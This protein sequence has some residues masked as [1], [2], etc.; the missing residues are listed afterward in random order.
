MKRK[1]L[2]ASII[3]C[4]VLVFTCVGTG[5]ATFFFAAQP[6]KAENI[7]TK[8]D[9]IE[10]NYSVSDGS[11][12]AENYYDVYFFAQS[13]AADTASYSN[14]Q[15]NY[16]PVSADTES[17][18][19]ASLTFFNQWSSTNRTVHA[20]EY[21]YW[22]ESTIVSNADIEIQE[23]RSSYNGAYDYIT[24]YKDKGNRPY[25]GYKHLR[26]YQSITTEQFEA[27]GNPA[28]TG[29]DYGNWP[30]ENST[31]EGHNQLDFSGWTANRAVASQ[32]AI[33]SKPKTF[34]DSYIGIPYT[35]EFDVVYG[36]GQG[37]FDYIDA[38]TSLQ[39]LDQSSDDGTAAGD[40]VIFLY[41]IYTQGKNHSSPYHTS[42]RLNTVSNGEQST[43]FF[44]Q[45]TIRNGSGNYQYE[46]F[47]LKN[48]VVDD[49]SNFS[50]NIE[51]AGA[52]SNIGWG[53]GWETISTINSSTE[54]FYSSG[55]Y[56][57]YVYYVT[58]NDS[59]NYSENQN[60][61]N[62][63]A[64]SRPGV[65]VN[66]FSGYGQDIANNGTI[67]FYYR[68]II[69]RTYEFHLLGGAGGINGFIY[70]TTSAEHLYQ[71]STDYTDE[72]NNQFSAIYF[73]SNIFLGD[74]LAKFD[75]TGVLNGWAKA[76]VF[77]IAAA[78]EIR[79]F[80]I[81]PLNED[82]LTYINNNRSNPTEEDPYQTI[83]DG[84]L[85]LASSSG[86][87]PDY[88]LNR[89]DGYDIPEMLKVSSAGYYDFVYK[90]TFNKASGSTGSTDFT[91]Y[92]ASIKVGIRSAQNTV[93]VKIYRNDLT[94]Y[95]ENG[96]IVHS[97]LPAYRADVSLGT[98]LYET[99][100]LYSTQASISF[101]DLV[102]QL[103]NNNQE[104]INHVTQEPVPI[105]GNLLIMK[106]YIF[107]IR[108]KS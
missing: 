21:G 40:N 66:T 28:T 101:T 8:L 56:N 41:P 9:D 100:F 96:F 22:P 10:E 63:A 75:S 29:R 102:A 39:S 68:I 25:V 44:G 6:K 1:G 69:E 23:I 37:D 70:E 50:S 77:T 3:L 91:N 98:A 78:D 58:Q 42:M 35:K 67:N 49:I 106:N 43:K 4:F 51:L 53:V 87:D 19:T 74:P 79:P 2:I 7:Q 80:N 93:F 38:F 27:I 16:T 86:S 60:A 30:N 46:I 15:V 24:N 52:S 45:E 11:I 83:D 103:E 17:V 82:E 36:G 71:I 73:S 90:I 92:V 99:N 54:L 64:E 12:K 97:S 105:D 26:V 84:I 55:A 33:S 108:N 76:N 14:G 57:V 81:E 13:Y 61:A 20:Q 65:F 107:Y 62:N 94:Q 31:P 48:I 72:G 5:L 85:S 59:R 32:F 104:L 95:D 88:Q 89:T 18:E 34:T 47:S